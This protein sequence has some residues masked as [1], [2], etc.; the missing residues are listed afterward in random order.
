MSKVKTVTT[1][2]DNR[3]SNKKIEITITIKEIIIITKIMEIVKLIKGIHQI[4]IIA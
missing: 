2:P 4:T 3:N 1:L